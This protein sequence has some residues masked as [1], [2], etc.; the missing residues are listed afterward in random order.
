MR[1]TLERFLLDVAHDLLRVVM[2]NQKKPHMLLLLARELEGVIDTHRFQ[3]EAFSSKPTARTANAELFLQST[4]FHSFDLLR[5][6]TLLAS[7]KASGCGCFLTRFDD[8]DPNR[9]GACTASLPP[10][11][12]W[13][14]YEDSSLDFAAG[15]NNTVPTN[16]P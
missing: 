16:G 2:S 7:T 4:P 10:G 11:G 8:V 3:S 9:T 12:M 15:A 13:F 6:S 1:G 5:L 14:S